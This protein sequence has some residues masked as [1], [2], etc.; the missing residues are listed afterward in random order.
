MSRLGELLVREN[1]IS[2]KEL[3]AARQQAQ[4]SGG[5]LGYS[6]TK[7]GYIAESELTNFLSKQYGVPSINLSEFDID[8]DVIALMPREVA[9]KHQCIP[10]NRAGSLTSACR[11]SASCISGGKEMCDTYNRPPSRPPGTR[12]LPNFGRPKVTV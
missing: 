12:R 4:K 3:E 9:I 5:R 7:L 10:I 8:A 2:T 1:L 11:A 6:L